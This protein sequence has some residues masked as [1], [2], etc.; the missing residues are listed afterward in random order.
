MI[1]AVRT[2]RHLFA[3][4]PHVAVTLLAIGGAM[5]TLALP[6][7]P[8]GV[9]FEFVAPTGSYYLFLA[10]VVLG[11]LITVEA[12]KRLFYARLVPLPANFVTRI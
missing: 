6:F 10:M 8:I 3:S 9:W 11:F 1:F 5:L 4:R 7:L 2:R 12:V